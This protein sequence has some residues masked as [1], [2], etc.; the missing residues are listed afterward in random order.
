MHRAQYKDGAQHSRWLVVMVELYFISSFLTYATSRINNY[1][2]KS[3][4]SDFATVDQ[5]AMIYHALSIS[6][7][8]PNL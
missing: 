6:N 4:L 1:T 8:S 5:D 3:T 2:G 7:Y